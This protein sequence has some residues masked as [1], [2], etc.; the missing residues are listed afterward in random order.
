MGEFIEMKAS[1]LIKKLEKEIK[2]NGD[3]DVIYF[4]GNSC[5]H[6]SYV[7]EGNDYDGNLVIVID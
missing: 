4:N 7:G 5:E 3:K 1:A 2:D 6:V